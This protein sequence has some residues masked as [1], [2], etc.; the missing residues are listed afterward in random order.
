MTDGFIL[1]MRSVNAQCNRAFGM[2]T[3]FLPDANWRPYFDDQMTPKQA[4]D[5]AVMDAWD[6]MLDM[7]DMSSFLEKMLKFKVWPFVCDFAH[8]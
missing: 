2:D 1:W 7:A 4:I 6:D 8:H 5:E 3:D